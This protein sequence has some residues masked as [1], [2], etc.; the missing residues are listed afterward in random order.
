MKRASTHFGF[1]REKMV[2]ENLQWR[3]AEPVLEL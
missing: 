1:F 2:G 3:T